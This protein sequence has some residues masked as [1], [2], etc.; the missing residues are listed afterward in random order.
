MK[1]TLD[2]LP[3]PSSVGQFFN[4]YYATLA[5]NGIEFTK[6]DNMASLDNLQ[7]AQEIE[8]SFNEDGTWS[9]TLGESIDIE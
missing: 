1:G 7:A 2:Y 5:E 9:E 3:H 6:C 8:F 4:D